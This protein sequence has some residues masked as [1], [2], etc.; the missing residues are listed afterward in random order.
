MALTRRRYARSP[1]AFDDDVDTADAST[2]AVLV[3]WTDGSVDDDDESCELSLV[4][5]ILDIEGFNV[6]DEFLVKELAYACAD[7]GRVR[8]YFYRV[9]SFHELSERDRQQARY[10]HRHIHGLPFLDAPDDLEQATV[11]RTV[12]AL[13]E[14]ARSSGH[15]IGYKGGRVERD[16][17][18]RL[19]YGDTAIDLETLGCPRFDALVRRY[20]PGLARRVTLEDM[21]TRHHATPRGRLAHCPRAEAR[22]FLIWLLD[23]LETRRRRRQQRSQ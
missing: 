7:D 2:T 6:A 4:K 8:G 17:I 5:Y 13:C 23:S 15:L 10:V 18:T 22:Y 9:G 20:G 14:S 11:D 3:D 16:L 1:V 21:C 12:S 19:G